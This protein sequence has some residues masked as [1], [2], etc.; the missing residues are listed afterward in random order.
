LTI[1]GTELMVRR[2]GEYMHGIQI[3]M[4][5]KPTLEVF[6]ICQNEDFPDVGTTVPVFVLPEHQGVW[7][8]SFL[9]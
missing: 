9:Q 2:T 5:Y 7:L 3:S 8:Q 6:S 1:D 4:F